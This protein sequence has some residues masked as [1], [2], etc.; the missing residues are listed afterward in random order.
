MKSWKDI[1]GD[2]REV[3]NSYVIGD[4]LTTEE[5][6]A[7]QNCLKMVVELFKLVEINEES[8]KEVERC[9]IDLRYLP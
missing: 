1:Q 2:L 3:V 4:P 9:L 8:M 7:M 6:V 5:L